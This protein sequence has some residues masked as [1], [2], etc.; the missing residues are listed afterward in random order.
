MRSSEYK[1]LKEGDRVRVFFFNVDSGVIGKIIA[2]DNNGI[3]ISYE[4]YNGVK[5]EVSYSF[6]LLKRI[7]CERRKKPFITIEENGIE[8]ALRVI[9]DGE[10]E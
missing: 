9:R 8:R 2:K 4:G 6:E 5:G 1:K 7:D 10:L 3:T